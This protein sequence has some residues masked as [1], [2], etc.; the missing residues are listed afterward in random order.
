M[1]SVSLACVVPAG[2]Q[3]SASAQPT[4]SSSQSSPSIGTPLPVGFSLNLGWNETSRTNISIPVTNSQNAAMTILGVQT[5]ANFFV[6]D[7]PQTIPANGKGEIL[8]MY[9]AQTNVTGPSDILRLMTNFGELSMTIDHGR[10]QVASLSGTSLN[11]KVGETPMAKSVTLTIAAGST[12]VPQS[13]TATGVGNT[14][15]LTA[16]GGGKYQI[17]VIPGSTA[18]PEEFPVVIVYSPAVPDATAVVVA[19]VSQN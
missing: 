15:S 12:V 2:A 7:F 18:T 4:S 14:A 1:L 6:E 3:S 13:V 9:Q 11:W 8:L 19:N 17:S 16:L 5:T 10:T